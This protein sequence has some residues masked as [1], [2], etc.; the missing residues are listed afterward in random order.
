MIQSKDSPAEAY[1]YLSRCGN[2][3]GSS[4]Q[5][6]SQRQ[7]DL[8]LATAEK[9]GYRIVTPAHEEYPSSLYDLTKPPPPLVLNVLGPA[10]LTEPHMVAIVGS[11]NATSYGLAFTERLASDLAQH[12]VTIVSG[13][14]RGIDTRAHRG[15][16]QAKGKTLAVL[17]TG[18]CECYPP[19]NRKLWEEIAAQGAVVSEYSL[20]SP[21]SSWKFPHRNRLI[22]GLCQTTII[23]QGSLKSGAMITA[24]YALNMSR[25]VMAVPGQVGQ[26]QSIGPNELLASGAA[27]VRDACDVLVALGIS[28]DRDQPKAE[29]NTGEPLSAQEE[30]VCQALEYE[31][32]TVDQL[33]EETNLNT[34]E[35]MVTLT[36][37][38]I[39]GLASNMNGYLW[40]RR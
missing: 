37:L 18:V 22:A 5:F 7:I 9:N 2:Q 10:K 26:A 20:T 19:E 6:P 12:G 3:P 8:L 38:Q 32:K 21:P 27:V 16:L 35:L 14:A 36:T 29:N 23:V 13:L 17:G 11:R 31:G 33:V 24:D 39:A 30:C 25:N 4:L 1:A 28:T 15:A 40:H 34:S